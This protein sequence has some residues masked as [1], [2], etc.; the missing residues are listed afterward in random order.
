MWATVVIAAGYGLLVGRRER[1]A[2]EG[3]VAGGWAFFAL[4]GLYAL[5]LLADLATGGPGT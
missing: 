1:S 4:V 3:A 5:F 2:E